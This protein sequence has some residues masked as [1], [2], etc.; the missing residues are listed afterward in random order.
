MAGMFAYSKSRGIF[1]GK[2]WE[3]G[4]IGERPE[5]NKKMY[6]V[7]LTAKELVSFRR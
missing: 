6:G 1:G 4:I 2:S 3:G 7:A 5:A